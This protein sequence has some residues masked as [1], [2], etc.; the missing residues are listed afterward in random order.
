VSSSARPGATPTTIAEQTATT[1]AVLRLRDVR[2]RRGDREILR[3]ID[4]E[5]TEGQRW[6]LLGPNGS[7]KTS[8]VR[9]ASLYEFPTLGEVELL[10]HRGGHVDLRTLRHRVGVT[11]PAVVDL[12]RPELTPLQLVIS[13]R[14]G[15]LVPWWIEPTDDDVVAARRQLARV[16]CAALEDRTFGTLS[17]GERQRVLLARTLIT[18]PA[19]LLLDEPSATL[20]LGGREQLLA[21]LDALAD[22]PTSPPALLVTHH[23]EEIPP[24]FTHAALLRDGSLFAQGP[25]DDV[26]TGESL[27][28]CFGMPLAVER[29]SGR[30]WAM[31]RTA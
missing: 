21:T 18:D 15:S 30:W 25:I 6:V 5:I 11:S 24:R 27:S 31:G 13:A 9:I 16:G 2:L 28:A 29:R 20:D 19:L 22:D 3:G 12:L 23:V 10:G 4:F 26:L 1:A 8:L 14:H 17:S 7:G